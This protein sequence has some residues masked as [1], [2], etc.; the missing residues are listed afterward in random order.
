M[1]DGQT[2]T[3]IY[4]LATRGLAECICFGT[5]GWLVP[6]ISTLSYQVYYGLNRL[7]NVCLFPV[8]GELG[9]DVDNT[10]LQVVSGSLILS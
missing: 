2:L 6:G 10:V 3:A 4:R 1:L 5:L 8:F 7:S 9:D